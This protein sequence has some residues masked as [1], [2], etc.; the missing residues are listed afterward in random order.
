[1]KIMIVGSCGKLGSQVKNLAIKKHKILSVDLNSN[2]YKNLSEINSKVDLII[3]TSSHEQSVNSTIY[4]YKHN[5]PIVI[6]CTGHTKNEMLEIKSYSKFIPI[7]IAYN[8]S[9]A[10]QLFKKIVHYLAKNFDCDAHLHEIHHKAKKDSP[11]GTAKEIEQIFK[12]ERKFLSIS[13]VR[14]GNIVGEHELTFFSNDETIK[15][16][17]T[18]QSRI[19]FAN[20]ILKASEFIIN[21]KPGLYNMENLVQDKI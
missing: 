17:H 4:A 3:D 6:A 7:F 18:A 15:I 10:I 1:M 21:K 12:K 8:M 19:A 14:A 13:S 11:S 16:S 9:Y 5:I 2:E 20:G